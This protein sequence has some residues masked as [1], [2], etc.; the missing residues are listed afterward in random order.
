MQD[1]Y[2][3][4]LLGSMNTIKRKAAFTD[5]EEKRPMDI[6]SNLNYKH[7]FKSGIITAQKFSLWQIYKESLVTRLWTGFFPA[8]LVVGR[9]KRLV[10]CMNCV[11]WGSLRM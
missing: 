2:C 1:E 9:Y 7:L 8:A 3:D 5:F 11:T 10:G 4:H 6:C